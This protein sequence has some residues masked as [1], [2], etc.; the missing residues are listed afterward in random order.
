[1]SD[2]LLFWVNKAVE[3]EEENKLLEQRINLLQIAGDEAIK[4]RNDALRERDGAR[5]EAERLREEL[6]ELKNTA[7]TE[8]DL[9]LLEEREE[10][11]ALLLEERNAALERER[12]LEERE[13]LGIAH[14]ETYKMLCE[15]T[16]ELE[17]AGAEA[18]RLRELLEEAREEIQ[19]CYGRDISLTECIWQALEGGGD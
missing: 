15:R 1:M 12:E 14:S 5:A 3:C 13:K 6:Q 19:N 4:Q 7:I 8:I 9:V 16:R 18:E 17:E 10:Q 2:K 11:N